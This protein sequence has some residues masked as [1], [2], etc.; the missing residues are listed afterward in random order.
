M[1]LS[2]HKKEKLHTR[3]IEISTYSCDDNHILV[4]GILKDDRFVSYYTMS[5]D[6]LPPKTVH[7]MIIRLLI[8]IPSLLIAETEVEMPCVPYEECPDVMEDMDKLTGMKIAPGFT[9]KVRRLFGGNQGCAHLT[10]LILA[11]APAV[12]QGYWTS[13]AQKPSDTPISPQVLEK[14]L[15]DTCKVWKRGGKL[16]EE[17]V[18]NHD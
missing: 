17:I 15:F 1:S 7:H 16:A 11:M 14:Y 8:E 10:T 9:S 2:K 6:K 5:G 12:M 13:R 18:G 4:Q 3:N